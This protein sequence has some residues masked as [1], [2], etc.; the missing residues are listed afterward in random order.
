[1]VGIRAENISLAP[2]G[3]EGSLDAAVEVVEP[4]GHA[5]LLTVDLGGQTVKVQVPSTERVSPGETVGLRFEQSALR[6]F[7]TETQLGLTA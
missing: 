4:L 2:R 5:T 3:S 1:M 7:D 6:F